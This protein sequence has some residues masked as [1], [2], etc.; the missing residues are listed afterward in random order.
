MERESFE[1]HATAALMNDLFVNVKV[2]REERPDLDG[3]YMQAVQ[4]LTGQGGWPMTVFLL[5]DGTPFYGGTYYPP[6]RRHGLPAFREVLRRVAEAYRDQKAEVLEGARQLR[7][8]IAPAALAPGGDGVMSRTVLSR[9]LGGFA[10][11]FDTRHGGFG[12]GQKFPQAPNLDA[13]L[14][15]SRATGDTDALVMV[16]KTL[17]EMASGGIWD[18]LGG[19]FHRYTVDRQWRVPHF[20]KMLYDNAQLVRT[21]LSAWQVTGSARYASI[22]RETLA[23]ILREMTTPNGAFYAAQDADSEGEEGKFFAWSIDEVVQALGTED[24]RVV[25]A[26][27]GMTVS[28]N[29]EGRNVLY[30]PRSRD[31]V[32]AEL[33]L[34]PGVIDATIAR[35]RP[36]LLAFRSMRVAPA[37]DDKVIASWNGMMVRA[38]AEAG[39]IL[40]DEAYTAVASRAAD[41]LFTTLSRGGNLTE[42]CDLGDSDAGLRL[43]RIASMGRTHVDAF[44]ED[45]ASLGLATLTLAETT[46]NGRWFRAA[47]ACACAIMERF[48]DRAHGG[49]FD[50]GNDHEQ[51]VARPKDLY[52]NAVPSGSSMA[53]ELLL[54]LEALG[55]N[56]DGGDVARDYLSRLV[57]PMATH[58][59]AFG[60]LIGALDFATTTPVQVALVGTADDPEAQGLR[61]SV[62]RSY[63]PNLVVA[64]RRGDGIDD[65]G[66][67]LLQGRLAV[68]GTPT[69]YVCE[70]FTCRLPTSDATEVMRQIEVAVAGRA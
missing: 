67:P 63:A 4:A 52:D 31:E 61:D 18:H 23:Y 24:A 6:E 26:W 16:T 57:T 28:G 66:V 19:G 32:A 15:I 14:R 11:T 8:A 13:L 48:V 35:A 33:G 45:Y 69:A 37:R 68:G 34:E 22:V 51:L 21:Y 60:T 30:Q 70:G 39:A 65:G 43:W 25:V 46:G 17:D 36:A 1:D 27:F 64:I 12:Q 56:G 50:T 53:C 55:M 41:A 54:R 29:F 42:G 59:G 62:W 2:D 58:P 7:E 10:K 9:S 5:P 3:I 44:L 20:E 49:F 38:F 47:R 40:R